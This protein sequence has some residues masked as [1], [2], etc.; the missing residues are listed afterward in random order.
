MKKIALALVL[1]LL[2]QLFPVKVFASNPQGPLGPVLVLGLLGAFGSG[3]S[4]TSDKESKSEFSKL[5]SYAA[6]VDLMKQSAGG[7]LN[8]LEILK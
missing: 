6:N 3:P 4:A 8:T 5:N 1:G 7:S 2:V